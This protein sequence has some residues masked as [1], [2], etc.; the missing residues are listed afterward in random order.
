MV[1]VLSVHGPAD[2]SA[3]RSEDRAGINH[4]IQAAQGT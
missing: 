4:S 1:D 2:I 3:A